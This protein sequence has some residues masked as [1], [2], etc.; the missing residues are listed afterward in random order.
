M[1]PKTP[2]NLNKVVVAYLD[3]RREKGF[4]YNF[5]V[6]RDSFHL[7]RQE[8]PHHERGVEVALKE[9]KAVFFVKDFAGNREYRGQGSTEPGAHGRKIEVTFSDGEKIFGSTQGYNPQRLGF[10]MFPADSKSNELR[11]FVIN[12]NVRGVK[13]V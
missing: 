5:S 13:S 8:N 4:A 2:Q 10:F 9:L 12:Q 3:G 11:I 1:P 7:L 6:S